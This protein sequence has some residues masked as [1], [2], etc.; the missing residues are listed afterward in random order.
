MDRKTAVTT[1]WVLVGGAML[2]GGCMNPGFHN[3]EPPGFSATFQQYDRYWQPVEGFNPTPLV[4]PAN[5]ELETPD[6]P[7][8]SARAKV[9]HEEVLTP[10]RRL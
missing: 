1:S 3:Q 10:T 2:L 4:S 7:S 6:L 8:M 5:F 9:P